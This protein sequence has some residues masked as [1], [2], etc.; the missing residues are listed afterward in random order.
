[1]TSKHRHPAGFIV[2]AQP[3]ERVKPPAGPEWVHELK[4]DG[5]RLIVRHDGA[6]AARFPAI[7]ETALRLDATAKLSCPVPMAS[8]NSIHS[9]GAIAPRRDRNAG[10]FGGVMHFSHS[11]QNLFAR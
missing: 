10:V 3:I 8:R 4:H 1:M 2:P 6:L 11:E 9:G 5:Y 7:T